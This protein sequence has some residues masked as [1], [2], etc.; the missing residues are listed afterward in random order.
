MPALRLL[1][2][3]RLGHKQTTARS[4][5]KLRIEGLEDRTVPTNTPCMMSYS[6]DPVIAGQPATIQV[7]AFD[8]SGSPVTDYS[9]DVAIVDEATGTTL[10]SH[11]FTA[12][13]QGIFNV[14]VVFPEADANTNV[15]IDV[16]DQDTGAGEFGD[17]VSVIG[18]GGGG[19]Q[20]PSFDFDLTSV[21]LPANDDIVPGDKLKFKLNVS[22]SGDVTCAGETT[23]QVTVGSDTFTP[24][25]HYDIM[26]NCTEV[27]PVTIETPELT[28]GGVLDVARTD[29]PKDDQT[30][31]PAGDQ[32][33]SV[34]VPP[35]SEKI[36]GQVVQESNTGDNS[37]TS[38]LTVHNAWQ[39]GI[40][41]G[42]PKELHSKT[43]KNFT[44]TGG[45]VGTLQKDASGTGW[46]LAFTGTGPTSVATIFGG[47][48]FTLDS[49]T[50]DSAMMKFDALNATA[51]G[52]VNFS[53]GL[54]GLLLGNVGQPGSGTTVTIASGFGKPVAINAGQGTI[55]DTTMSAG[56]G[57]SFLAVKSWVNPDGG[58]NA[59]T[60][61]F[62]D[63]VISGGDFVP[64]IT[65][66]D[67]GPITSAG[68]HDINIGG[69][70]SGDWVTSA[71][72]G[73]AGILKVTVQGDASNWNL[74]STG[75]VESLTVK[76]SDSG[77]IT[78]YGPIASGTGL[79][80]IKVDGLVSG[81]WTAGTNPVNAVNVGTV[82]VNSA[83]NWTLNATG[84]V[85]MVTVNTDWTGAG[86]SQTNA[87]SAATI[88][89]LNV[90]GT[91]KV[92]GI[93]TTAP[94]PTGN[95][96]I[97]D[98]DLHDVEGLDT[99][100][101]PAGIT[102]MEAN[103]WGVNTKLYANWIYKIAVTGQFAANLTLAGTEPNTNYSLSSA[104]IGEL[105]NVAG[106]P[107][108]WIVLSGILAL[109][110]DRM[111]FAVIGA[112]GNI[113]NVEIGMGGR[114]TSGLS[115]G[116]YDSAV[117]AAAFGS[118]QVDNVATDSDLPSGFSAHSFT[119]YSRDGK[120]ID[121]T[122]SQPDKVGTM[123]S[124]QII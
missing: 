97:D 1:R 32:T 22:N 65:T 77:G 41:D 13:D 31:I 3:I 91:I 108:S 26:A 62:V 17:L 73:V 106:A 34:T 75:P 46:D 55:Q 107:S 52:L 118:V 123:Y 39:F 109:V 117:S 114:S 93:I 12:G 103:S 71:A 83:E 58:T 115:A 84:T 88:G 66:T 47:P 85:K 120:D 96:S 11:Q 36:K 68:I 45:G 98:L 4:A 25:I 2:L 23:I 105:G 64:D 21:D 86:P 89:T 92:P 111:D 15:I 33:V 20:P 61:P 43:G 119:R 113:K 90:K 29:G 38:T 67:V 76:G 14:P 124:A 78:V 79:D 50:A 7:E 18:G 100:S 63:K 48:A 27:I 42:K 59:I 8:D 104:K 40:I 19:D 37:G 56:D 82:T 24:T 102:E 16:V 49:L 122:A 9:D 5:R 116:F 81:V 53:G 112:T 70:V 110:A 72:G 95:V 30:P 74:Y 54:G 80:D 44:L 28:V 35:I 60:A 69:N 10:G 101:V 94:S 6:P 51:V 87:L 57:I 99:L 121:I